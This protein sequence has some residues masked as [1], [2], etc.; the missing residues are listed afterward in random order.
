MYAP[1][2]HSKDKCLIKAG[3]EPLLSSDIFSPVCVLKSLIRVPLSEVVANMLPSRFRVI[4]AIA[5]L[6]ADITRGLSPS[7]IFPS[8]NLVK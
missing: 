1:E 5:P 8:R 7:I 4:H 2:S 6:C 3:S